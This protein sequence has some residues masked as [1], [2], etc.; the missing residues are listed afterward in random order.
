MTHE[1]LPW[2]LK[3]LLAELDEAAEERRKNK[4][5]Y[6]PLGVRPS[7]LVRKYTLT[8]RISTKKEYMDRVASDFEKL[9][10]YL[11]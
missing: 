7:P 2:Y 6:R 5:K 3:K 9:V 8:P 1:Q 4:G 11:P 10:K